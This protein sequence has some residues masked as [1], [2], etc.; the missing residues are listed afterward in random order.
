MRSHFHHHVVL[1]QRGIHDRHLPLAKRVI[2]RIVDELG[3]QPEP[4]RSRPIEHDKGLLAPILLIAVHIHNLRKR[5][6]FRLHL[7]RPGVKFGEIHAL[8]RILILRATGPATDPQILNGL[9]IGWSARHLRQFWTQPANHLVGAEAAF[10]ERLEGDEHP[11]RI[12]RAGMAPAACEAGDAGDGRIALDDLYD[13]G[14]FLPHR[15]KRDILRRLDIAEQPAGILLG[16]KPFWHE[17]VKIHRE[18][19]GG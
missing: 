15:L 2:Q 14:E 13:F 5:S 19:H 16:E 10:F 4:G 6:Q 1:I 18:R 11:P 17:N 8:Q 12:G 9:Q 3:T 7:R